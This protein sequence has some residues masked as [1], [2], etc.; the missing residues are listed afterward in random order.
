MESTSLSNNILNYLAENFEISTNTRGNAKV[1]DFNFGGAGLA[2]RF[3]KRFLSDRKIYEDIDKSLLVLSDKEIIEEVSNVLPTIRERLLSHVQSIEISKVSDSTGIE[4][5]KDAYL[6]AIPV[7]DMEDVKGR[8]IMVD[9]S[10]LRRSLVEEKSWERIVGSK[11]VALVK[12]VG[13]CGRFK[14][15]PRDS[16]PYS[17]METSLGKETL[18]NLY[19]PP[20]YRESRDLKAALDPRFIKF[21]DGLFQDSCRDYAYNWLYHSCFKRM[22][23]Y[24]VLVGAGGIGKNLLA[25]A[26]KYIHTSFNFK[27]A[28]PSALE[29][30]FNGHLENC[31]M[32]YYDECKF[33]AGKEGRTIRKN[34]LKEWAN[35][36]VPIENKGQDPI[37]RDIFC[38]AII[39]TNNDSDVHL[40][41]LDRKFSVMELSEERLEKRLGLEDTQFLWEYIK[42]P[43]FSDAFINYLEKKVDL[44]FNPHVEYKGP[45]FDQLVLSSLYGW[46]QELLD[47]IQNSQTPHISIKDCR[48]NISLFPKH[49]TKVDDFLKNFTVDRDSLGKI[50]TIDGSPKIKVN[51]KF[52][53]KTNEGMNL[54]KEI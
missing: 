44:K 54:N 5:D 15:D 1:D 27:K 11:H 51:E 6:N 21:L 37:N 47:R 17:Q 26:L 53:P 48:E 24:L 2:K 31:T 16:R 34:K 36:C 29:S 52:L 40:D 12:E 13:Y 39:A 18:Y 43:G 28:P 41:Q 42:D 14:Y 35:E 8:A 9:K 7:V 30:K 22:P 10:S 50:V 32:L 45:K 3:C 49:N 20:V 4:V 33:S 46:Q 38:S 19:V 23:V 25:E